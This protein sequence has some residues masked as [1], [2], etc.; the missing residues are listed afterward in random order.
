MVG[1]TSLDLI[2]E[3]AGIAVTA[4]GVPPCLC[5]A[6]TRRRCV[7][8]L[9]HSCRGRVMLT[10]RGFWLTYLIMVRLFGWPGLAFR[11]SAVKDVEMLLVSRRWVMI[12]RMFH[13]VGEVG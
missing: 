3:L 10:D 4:R 8:L 1:V 13:W 6:I 5:R 9:F 7:D 12:E 11:S 2:G